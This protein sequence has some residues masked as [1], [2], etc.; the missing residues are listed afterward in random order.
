M[1]AA[2]TWLRRGRKASSIT[3]EGAKL[4]WKSRGSGPAYRLTVATKSSFADAKTYL[5]KGTSKTVKG[6]LGA[7]TYYARVQVVTSGDAPR[8]VNSPKLTLKTKA[9][10]APVDGLATSH[11]C[12][13]QRRL[14]DRQREGAPP[15]RSAARAVAA[16][17]LSQ[18]PDVIG[19]QEVSQGQA[20]RDRERR[21]TGPQPGGGPRE[22]ARRSPYWMANEARYNCKNLKTPYKGMG[23]DQ[24]AANSQ[25]IVYNRQDPAV[26]EAGFEEDP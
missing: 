8:S 20:R 2:P 11:G 5:V 6:L 4:S 10:P 7:K 15:G 18:K 17:I 16:T 26:G 1:K 23:H 24:G 22:P 13:L 9:N 21:P 25:K 19:L 3:S 12:Q 14:G